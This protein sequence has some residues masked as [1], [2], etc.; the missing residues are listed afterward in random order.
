M[1]TLKHEGFLRGPGLLQLETIQK[2]YEILNE[3]PKFRFHKDTI[4]DF[5]KNGKIALFY[6]ET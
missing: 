5:C 2:F 6:S 1:K 4:V 3:P